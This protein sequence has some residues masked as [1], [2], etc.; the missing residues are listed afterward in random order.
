LIVGMLGGLEGPARAEPR[1]PAV[2]HVAAA[3]AR[4]GPALSTGD[5]GLTGTARALR[6]TPVLEINSAG[7]IA[8]VAPARTSSPGPVERFLSPGDITAAVAPHATDVEQCYR[9]RLD[10]GAHLAGRLDVTLS[11]AR[12]GTLLDVRTAAAGASRATARKIEACVR[13]AVEGVQF[14]ARR[15]DT[16]GVLPYVF[17]KT[18][19]SDAGPQLS[20]WSPKG[21]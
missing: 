9:E 5:L 11:I 17:Q 2:G 1:K 21:C 13:T 10:A 14:P 7:D 16:T 8:V 4:T 18:D 15:N 12:D 19:A 6:L 3:D 20:C